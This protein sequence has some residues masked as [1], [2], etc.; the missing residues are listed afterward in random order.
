M[1]ANRDPGTY[2]DR[3]A[4]EPGEWVVLNRSPTGPVDFSVDDIAFDETI[5][6]E[7]PG[8]RAKTYEMF[9]ETHSPIPLPKGLQNQ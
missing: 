9:L 7:I 4:V 2:E 6:E 1:I 8:W 5:Y 3:F